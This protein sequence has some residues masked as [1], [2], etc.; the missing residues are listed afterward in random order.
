[1]TLMS[2]LKD[3]VTIMAQNLFIFQIFKNLKRY[4]II[5]YPYFL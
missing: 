5:V 1:M 3:S 2:K 4:K